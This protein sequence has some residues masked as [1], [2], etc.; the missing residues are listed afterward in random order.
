MIIENL[1][2]IMYL[3]EENRWVNIHEDNLFHSVSKMFTLMPNYSIYS[4]N[5]KGFAD[6]SF[7]ILS[8]V[9]RVILMRCCNVDLS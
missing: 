6:I 7:W 8:Q 3:F 2:F 5:A 1:I 4:N 9:S